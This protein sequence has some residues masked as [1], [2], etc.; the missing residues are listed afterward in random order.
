MQSLSLNNSRNDPQLTM[1]L[2]KT[3]AVQPLAQNDKNDVI[4]KTNK[5]AALNDPVAH[6]EDT[7]AYTVL[8]AYGLLD[9]SYRK[10]SFNDVFETCDLTPNSSLEGNF[11]K[12]MLWGVYFTPGCG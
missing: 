8:Q 3:A 7:P 2:F 11:W 5:A 4:M 6:G 1:S 12:R 10:E 9:T